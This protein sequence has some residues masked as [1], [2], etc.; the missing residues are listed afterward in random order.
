[1]ENW[2]IKN[3]KADF[4][5]IM[6]ECG[7]SEVLARCLVNKGF[8]TIEE[9]N[10]FLHPKLDK[11]HDP[12]TMKDMQKA[13]EL[14]SSKINSGKRIR[15]IGDYDVDGVVA[16]YILYRTLAKIGAKVDYE[17]PDRIKDGYGINGSMVEAAYQDGIDTILTC[18]NGIA[19]MEQIAAAKAYHLTVIV[20]D[21]HSIVQTEGGEL[22]LPPADAI[23]NPKQV[24]C[25]YPF[26]GLC[27]AAIAYKLSIELVQSYEAEDKE[28]F[29][30]ELLSY[31]AIATICDVMDLVDENRIIVKYG[32][33]LLKVTKNRGLI[34]LM[35]T[36]GIDRGQLNTF[37]L[38]FVIGPCLNASGRLDTAK[39]GLELLLAETEAEAVRLAAE[40]R[41]LNDLRKNMTAEN[42]EK[43]MHHIED[44][45]MDKDKILVVL[46][47]DCHESIAGI[48]AG[49][50]RE[51]YNRPTL[52]LTDAESCVKGSGRSIEQYNMVA[53]L[54][55]CREL[56]LK[57]GGHPMAAGL[58]MLPENVDIL[59][60]ALNG[61]TSL[62]D[63]ML[64]PKVTIDIHLPLGFIN[65][66][67]VNEL[68]LLEPFGKGNEK[69]LFAEK[70]LK[71]KSAFVVGKNAS[72]LRL[73]VENQYGREMDAMYFGDVGEFFEYIGNTYGV[74]EAER[75]KTG[76]GVKAAISITYFPK[77]NEYNGFRSI[78][79][80]IQNYR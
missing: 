4:N 36:S 37:H 53:E 38:G 72:G 25:A 50:V 19:A 57:M 67:L 47:E 13:C 51:K 11:L 29:I 60:E 7:V 35:D 21:H 20:T 75:L 71:I 6:Q 1:M 22:I 26:K 79:L 15:I 59:R 70:D 8:E 68:K 9:I 42:V 78:Q 65:E 41:N 64:I 33:E 58:S 30:Q 62:T 28:E 39:R 69:P 74:Q 43:A 56:F 14:L 27:G 45:G 34:A 17:I 77:I 10:A 52:I 3:K 18:D 5:L 73:R 46:L 54:Q 48:I 2:V 12:L 76:R 40:V 23:I 66:A 16:T 44:N 24:D 63:E 49:R 80:M 61:N 32:L 55:N 31:V